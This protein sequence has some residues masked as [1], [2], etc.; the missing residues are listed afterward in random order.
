LPNVQL[1][2]ELVDLVE[3]G[4]SIMVGT[5]DDDLQPDA[6]RAVGAKVSA[7]RRRITLYLPSTAG[8]QALANLAKHP[9]LAV[10]LVSPMDHVAI[11]MKGPC[12]DVHLATEEERTIPERYIT[13]QTE[14]LYMI[15]LPR[16]ITSRM[17]AWPAHA[18]T[19][20]I[21][22]IFVQTPGPGAGKRLGS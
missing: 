11:Q 12:V 18:V 13:S 16:G 2:K 7:D 8:A 19:F 4:G 17:V 20:E 21:E 6:A 9:F 15:G 10:G 22:D 3:G 1:P 14:L 5:R